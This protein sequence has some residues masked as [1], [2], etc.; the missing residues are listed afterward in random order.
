M[1]L[2]AIL[3]CPIDTRKQLAENI[4]LVGGTSMILGL[5][6]RLFAELKYLLLCEEYAG[7]LAVTNFKFHTPPAK[8]NYTCW[9]GASIFGATDAI[10]TRSLTRDQYLKEKVVP[11]WADLRFNTLEMARQG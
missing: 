1:I 8:P 2:D 11:D 3:T 7:R 5:K 10:S 9:L 6:A 4:V